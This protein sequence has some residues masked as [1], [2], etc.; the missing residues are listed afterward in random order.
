LNLLN[1][2]IMYQKH[3]EIFFMKWKYFEFAEPAYHVPKKD[4]TKQYNSLKKHLEI[5]FMKWKYFELAGAV[6]LQMYPK[7]RNT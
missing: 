4:N 7:E 1:Q 5:F 3:L 6:Y 2:Y